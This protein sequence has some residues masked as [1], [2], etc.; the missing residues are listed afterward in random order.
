MFFVSE[1]GTLG[2]HSLRTIS[3]PTVACIGCTA[4]CFK[5]DTTYY[6]MCEVCMLAANRIGVVFVTLRD[7]PQCSSKYNFKHMMLG[8]VPDMV[9]AWITKHLQASFTHPFTRI[10]RRLPLRRSSANATRGTRH[11]GLHCQVHLGV[12]GLSI[13]ITFQ[14]KQRK[15]MMKEVPIVIDRPYV[16]AR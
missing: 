7:A 2:I 15:S 10:L 12:H 16:M 8:S 3:E 4:E 1:W 14:S 9:P 6:A 11:H 5:M 13:D